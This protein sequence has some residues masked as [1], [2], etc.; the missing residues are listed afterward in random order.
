[1]ACLLSAWATEGKESIT[2]VF[3]PSFAVANA[4][5]TPMLPAPMIITSYSIV[6]TPSYYLSH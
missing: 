2:R 6:I 5:G 4:V 3:N 1:M